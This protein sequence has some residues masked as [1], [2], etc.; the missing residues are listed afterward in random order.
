MKKRL[1]QW[2]LRAARLCVFPVTWIAGVAAA[3]SPAAQSSASAQVVPTAEGAGT[4]VTETGD[5]YDI[6]GGTQAGGN[7]FHEFDEFSLAESQTANFTSDSGVFNIVGQVSSAAPSYIDGTV[8]VSGSDANLYL[9]NPSGVLFGPN[10][11]LSLGGSFTATTADQVEFNGEVLNVLEQPT[12]YAALNTDPSALHFTQ[13]DA[14]PVVNQGELSVD[15]GESLSLVGG[16]VVNTGRLEAPSGEIGLVAVGGNSTVTLATPGSLLSM[17]VNAAE[18]E[19]DLNGNDGL[20]ATALPVLLTGG[21]SQSAESLTVNDDGSVTLGGSALAEE[22]VV[23]SGTVA[24]T[25]DVSVSSDVDAGGSVVLVGESV[26]VVKGQIEASGTTGGTVRI[27]GDYRGEGVLPVAQTVVVDEASVVAANG[28]EAAGGSV[29]VFAE[30]EAV[31]QGSLSATGATEGG[32]VETSANY[33]TTAGIDVDTSGETAGGQ[34]LVDP[35]DVEVVSTASGP[36]QIE[37]SAI[38]SQIDGGSTFTLETSGAGTGFGDISLLT[39]INQTDASSSGG[40]ILRGRRFEDNNHKI[41]L[42]SS[43][44]LLFDINAVNS[45]SNPTSESIQNAVDAIGT[46]NG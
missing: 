15:A 10:A 5:Q 37:A 6:A 21:A 25:G 32:L 38:E 8:Q 3:L 30:E 45:E 28:T 14:S 43:G 46:V 35:V 20:E 42:A 22:F 41:N 19:M 40:L 29:V 39:S 2:T 1:Q 27:G 24:V 33:L 26:A 13:D 36:N 31:V 7:L 12:D 34:W 23:E 44:E 9:V 17:E 4:T 11:Q 16:S 18:F